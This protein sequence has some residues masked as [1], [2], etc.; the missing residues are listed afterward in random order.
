MFCAAAKAFMT[1]YR[2]ALVAMVS[3]CPLYV[4]DVDELQYLLVLQATH[5]ITAVKQLTH[6]AM[7]LISCMFCMHLTLISCYRL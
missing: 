4:V 7:K 3:G 1:N 6:L 2:V 5:E